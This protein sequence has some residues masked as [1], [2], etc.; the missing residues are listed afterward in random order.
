MTINFHLEPASRELFHAHGLHSFEVLMHGALGDM[1]S[2]ASDRRKLY[3]LSLV[4][5]DGQ[6]QC[7]YLKRM[8]GE[9]AIWLLKSLLAGRRPYCGPI[10]ELQL[11]TALRSAGFAVMRPVAW[12]EARRN[13]LPQGGFLVV[14][15]VQGADVAGLSATLPSPERRGLLRGVGQLI[16]RLH[17]AGFFQPVRLKDLIREEPSQ[18]LVM[19]DRETS[20]PWPVRFSRQRALTAL[21]RTA[22]RTLRDGHRFGPAGVRDFLEGY[23]EGVASRWTVARAE[24]RHLVFTRFRKELD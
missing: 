19:I 20:K 15:E 21:A 11:L 13:G 2:C 7:F 12:G 10:R 24:L 4:D 17:A 9:P 5:R 1:V 16:G 14:A 23:G 8:T 18:Q 6:R 22:R 3:R